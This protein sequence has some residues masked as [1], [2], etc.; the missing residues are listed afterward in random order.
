MTSSPS[1]EK[2]TSIVQRLQPG[3]TTFAVEE[4][5]RAGEH[6]HEPLYRFRSLRQTIW[7]DPVQRLP[8]TSCRMRVLDGLGLVDDDDQAFV[9]SSLDDRCMPCRL[10]YRLARL[11]MSPLIPAAFFSDW[12]PFLLH[13]ESHE[14]ARPLP[15]LHC[16]PGFQLCQLEDFTEHASQILGSLAASFNEPVH[17]RRIQ[18]QNSSS[19]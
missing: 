6:P 19:P 15:G 18:L 12:L 10:S 5:R 13:P 11:V 7:R 14:R 4:V 3:D 8:R 2:R 16:T 9:A 1:G 17:P